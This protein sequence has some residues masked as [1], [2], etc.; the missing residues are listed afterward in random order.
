[1]KAFIT[2]IAG[3]AGAHLAEHLLDSGDGV[4]GATLSGAW[5]NGA[6]SAALA[7]RVTGLP[8]FAWDIGDPCPPQLVEKLTTFAPTVIYHLAAISKATA[9]GV[10]E[11]TPLA[12]RINVQGTQHVLA[13]AA[14]LPS[15]PRVVVVSSSYVY[16]PA[17][18]QEQ[19]FAESDPPHPS[20]GYGRTKLAA[21]ECV[22]QALAEH[23][24]D[25]VIARAFQ[26]AGPRQ[27]PQ[28][29]LAEWCQQFAADSAAP[30]VMHNSHTWIDLSDVRDVVRAYRVLAE[31]GE[32][33]EVY[34]VGSGVARTSG[35]I[36]A[37]LLQMADP[38]RL[39]E[40]RS[41]ATKYTP[42]ADLHKI[43]SQLGWRPHIPLAQTLLET[44][45]WFRERQRKECQGE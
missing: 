13:L 28:F 14:Q 8:L 9:C 33:G 36:F 27:D 34:N 20:G 45:E 25:A 18:S 32:C 35:D 43:T 21:E 5:T 31:H 22:A 29:M 15:R 42:I 10:T 1:M 30:V 26:H 37:Q 6:G 16:G 11:P 23:N 24:V 44:L 17:V 7:D 2:G 38:G 41:T 12:Q 19:T 4:C 39:I 40:I 3:F